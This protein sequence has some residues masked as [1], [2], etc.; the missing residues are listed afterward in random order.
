[1]LRLFN[2]VD[3]KTPL[4]HALCDGVY[5]K[6]TTYVSCAKRGKEGFDCSMVATRLQPERILVTW[7]TGDVLH[8]THSYTESHELLQSMICNILHGFVGLQTVGKNCAEIITLIRNTYVEQTIL[9]SKDFDL[10]LH[11][12]YM[13][14]LKRLDVCK[15]VNYGEFWNRT[16]LG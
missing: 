10:L 6:C 16:L 12:L 9:L 8:M 11:S 1:M 14:Q 5:F 4:I 15:E 3:G 2:S 7:D 13:R